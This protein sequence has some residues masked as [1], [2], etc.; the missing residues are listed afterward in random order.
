MNRLFLYAASIAAGVAMLSAKQ[1]PGRDS[2]MIQ[3]EFIKVVVGKIDGVYRETYYVRRGEAWTEI[4][5]SGSAVRPEPSLKQDGEMVAAAY[6]SVT[7]IEGFP[8]GEGLQLTCRTPSGVI[9]KTITLLKGESFARIGITY[10]IEKETRLQSLWSTYSFAPDGKKYADYKPLDFV[11][12]P[13]LRPEPE[14]VIADHVFRSPAL[15]M[16]KNG[17]FAALLPDVG[18]LDIKDRMIRTTGDLQAETSD[19]P[20]FSYGLQNWI[21]EPYRLRNTHVF[22]VAPDSL[23]AVLRDTTVSIAFQLFV[24][25][26]AKPGEGFRGVVRYHWASSGSVNMQKAQ[27]PQ[28]EPFSGYIKKAWYQFLPDIALDV[29]Y[30]GQP[31]TLLR[32]A[33]LAWSNKLHKVAD[34]DSWFNVWFNAL[35]TAYGM[36][37]HGEAV[38][39]HELSR[40][41]MNV[42]NLAL[43]AP[44]TEGIAPSIFYFD[45][46]GGHWVADHAWGGIDNGKDLPMFHN[47]WTCYWLL[48]WID[49]TPERWSEIL[50][51]TKAFADFLVA[52]QQESGVI[53]SW[54][55]PENLEAAAQL[56][57]E[58]AETAGAALFLAEYYK[59]TKEVNYLL[60]AERSM[61]YI[62]DSVLPQQKWFDYETFFSCSR[63]PL[64][65]YDSYTHQ[66]PQNTLSMQQAAEAF[67]ELYNLTGKTEYKVRGIEVIDYLCLYQQVWS[68]KWLS[69]ELFGGFGVQNTDAEWS[70]S[71]QG[72]FAVTLMHYYEL[73]GEKEY[74]ERGVAALRA[75]FS[76]FESPTSPRT[77]E[78]Y[79]HSGYNQPAGVTGIHWGTGSS[80]VSIHLITR[81]YGDAYVD[82]K[83]GWGVG[84]DGCRIPAVTI[85]GSSVRVEVLNNLSASRTIKL[86]FGNATQGNFDLTVNGSKLGTFSSDELTRGVDVTI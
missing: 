31:V 41:A 77:A 14:H 30:Q 7:Q 79:A 35:R 1:S 20:F 24:L 53:S 10:Q 68:P 37:L 66:N 75:M 62:T 42:L 43:L 48:Q 47:A 26:D 85:E 60:A 59:R 34:N 55:N 11:F 67:Y 3:N 64:G 51:Y 4:L 76:L 50:H 71:R 72:Y 2:T 86:T 38:A 32:Q 56:R 58:N 82:M 13:Q 54:Y 45:S 70:D 57:D 80:V 40:R 23:A 73:T 8:Q 21:P 61:R 46:T 83:G 39:D 12:T 49:H 33:R 6:E 81:R 69:C 15:M 19:Q 27:G 65:F 63:K 22:Y 18:S 25:G 16:Q 52:H 84:I 9:Q 78:N 28:S 5:S 74:F 29:E 44:Q 36:Y 17:Y